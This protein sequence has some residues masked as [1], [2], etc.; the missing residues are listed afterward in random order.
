MKVILQILN[1]EYSFT[2]I[3]PNNNWSFCAP[4][5]LPQFCLSQDCSAGNNPRKLVMNFIIKLYWNH[6]KAVNDRQPIMNKIKTTL[7]LT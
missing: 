3:Y 4:L 6:M 7:N 5:I 2:Y 1:F